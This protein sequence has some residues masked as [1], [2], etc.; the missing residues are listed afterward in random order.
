MTESITIS[1]ALMECLGAAMNAPETPRVIML[2]G[3]QGIGKSTALKTLE[4]AYPDRLV[5]LSLDDFYLTHRERKLLA[6][7]AHALC[8]M[9]GPPGTHDLEMLNAT[10]DRI[11]NSQEKR[12]IAVPVFSKQQD[13][14]LQ[15]P[16]TLKL[17]AG[18]K[19][20]LLEGWLLGALADLAA[21]RDSPINDLE[22]NE[23]ADGI[24]RDWQEHHL[25][26]GY[27]ALWARADL[28][29]HLTTSS[30]DNVSAWR[31]QQEA[32]TL[33]CQP[34]DLPPERQRWVERFVKHY[35]RIT[36]RMIDGGREKGVSVAVSKDR[37]V[38][39][40]HGPD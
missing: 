31:V 39:S 5:T 1:D 29:C 36:R 6:N 28:F 40:S 22:A 37:Q 20:I 26:G 10:I 12:D 27:A 9:R 23:D 3:P 15:T 8:S 16:R 4:Q 17:S 24:W 2:S 14:R 30:F 34:E 19:T 7:E 35:E 33:G 11:L 13:D 38:Y 18:P 21:S 25:A 32:T